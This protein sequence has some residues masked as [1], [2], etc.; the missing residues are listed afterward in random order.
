MRWSAVRF[1]DAKD[2]RRPSSCDPSDLRG[3]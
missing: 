1:V 3:N 2:V